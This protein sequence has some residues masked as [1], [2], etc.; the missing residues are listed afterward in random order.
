MSLRRRRALSAPAI[1]IL[2]AVG[3]ALATPVMAIEVEEA[4]ES[5][6]RS[7]LDAA[8]TATAGA[9]VSAAANDAPVT[10]LSAADRL[11]YTNAFDALRRGQIDEARASARGASDRILV[12]LIEFEALFHPSHT[13]T[14]EEL[15]AWLE[16]YADL[17][18]AD[19]VYALAMRR[20]PDGA[21]EPR[22]PG[23][24]AVARTWAS[25]QA[26]ADQSPE[27]MGP[28]A[29][30]IAY[31][32]NDLAEAYRL[33][34]SIG[35]WWTAGLS[36]WRQN[37]PGRAL[38]AFE[39]VAHDPT[40]DAW[41]RAGAGVWASKAAAAAGRPDK[42]QPYLEHAAQWPASFYGQIALA[43]LGREPTIHND[44]PQPYL[45][46]ASQTFTGGPS[47]VGPAVANG[48]L[49]AF[50][51]S[52][53]QAR[54]TLAFAEVGRTEDARDGL[55]RGLRTAVGEDARRL[56][57]G[58]ARTL[59][60]RVAGPRDDARRIDANDF[61][62]PALEPEGGFVI[63]RALV[64]ALAR[65]E[66]GFN[67]EARSSVG[68][69]GIMQVM[70]TTAAE[71]AGDS[72]FASDPQRLWNPAVNMR[73]GQAYIR[74]M[75]DMNAFQGDVLRAVASYNAG[76]GPMLGALRK[77]GPDA[78]PLLLIETIDV[79]QARQY[80]EDVMAAYWI[81]Q[82]LLGGSLNTLGAV[83]GDA[84][85]IPASLDATTPSV[86]AP[87]FPLPDPGRLIQVAFDPRVGG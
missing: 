75:L 84:R 50:L 34:V 10:A 25:V 65:K 9:S 4:I 38:D 33:G 26:A 6:V 56:W 74:K 23:G 44:G 5:E 78:D 69:Y 16:Q 85:L 48:E 7:T 41:V 45:A 66:S 77:L 15:S 27:E 73:L 53:Q 30:R 68:A 79:P 31:N 42:V 22:R 2:A 32:N 39:R 72:G 1:A 64:Y 24:N 70:P 12:G 63:E 62:L 61:P 14:Y 52:D 37:D 82:R 47:D 58:L 19:R 67:A 80:V 71:L 87:A 13:A 55:K 76:P 35:D 40:E 20:R 21:P 46:Q 11:S 43:Q 59:G 51:Q 83:A 54:L 81:Y 28:K 49:N 86:T 29:A 60:A 17:P 8:L 3:A 18:S 36:A 57:I